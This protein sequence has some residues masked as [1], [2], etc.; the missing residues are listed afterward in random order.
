M[1]IPDS[2]SFGVVASDGLW[3]LEGRSSGSMV[4]RRGSRV[5][6]CMAFG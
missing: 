4:F 3:A 5:F 2:A 6:M 1:R